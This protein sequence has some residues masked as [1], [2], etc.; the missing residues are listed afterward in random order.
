MQFS[1]K[2]T[3]VGFL[4]AVSTLSASAVQASTSITQTETEK[5]PL[6]IESRISR[7][8]EAIKQRDIQQLETSETDQLMAGWLNGRRGGW[9][10]T[11][12]GG[13]INDRGGGGFLNRRRWRDGGRFYRH[14]RG[15]YY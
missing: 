9:L 2:I 13:F 10:K 14:R 1:S 6:S 8:T 12:R 7:L 15:R 4:V 11:R 5:A 3:F